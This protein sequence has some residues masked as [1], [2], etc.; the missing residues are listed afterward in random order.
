MEKKLTPVPLTLPGLMGGM[1]TPGGENPRK[2]GG[3]PFA[4]RAGGLGGGGGAWCHGR[5]Q[6]RVCIKGCHVS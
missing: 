4:L 1:I 6:V 3:C 5:Y 2:A